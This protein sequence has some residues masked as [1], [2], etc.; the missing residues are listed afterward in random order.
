MYVYSYGHWMLQ[1]A[2]TI[3]VQDV[4]VYMFIPMV[5]DKVAVKEFSWML[6]GAHMISMQYKYVCMR[7]CVSLWS[8]TIGIHY[9][10]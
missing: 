4:C 10:P 3:S 7:V 1:G 9:Q 2:H 5:N 8:I 6:Q